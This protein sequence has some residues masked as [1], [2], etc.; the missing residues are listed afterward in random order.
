MEISSERY[1][2]ITFITAMCGDITGYMNV[3]FHLICW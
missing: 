3:E 1:K 2:Q